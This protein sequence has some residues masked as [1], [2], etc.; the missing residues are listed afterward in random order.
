MKDIVKKL[1]QLLITLVSNN[2]CT[3]EFEINH[4]KWLLRNQNLIGFSSNISINELNYSLQEIQ[5]LL[6]SLLASALR[7][8]LIPKLYFEKLSLKQ[9]EEYGIKEISITIFEQNLYS[10]LSAVEN[11]E[12]LRGLKELAIS[13][14]N[15]KFICFNSLYE[16]LFC[17]VSRKSKGQFY[18]EL[19]IARLILDLSKIPD[20]KDII[21]IDPSCGAGAFIIA[22]LDYKQQKQIHKN[23]QILGVDIS[24]LA[25]LMSRIS[26][27]KWFN[28]NLGIKKIDFIPIF[29]M[30]YLLDFNHDLIKNDKSKKTDIIN[31]NSE[32]D[33]DARKYVKKIFSNGFDLIVGNPPYLRI[34]KIPISMREKHKELFLSATGSYDIYTL[35]IEHS[36]NLVKSNGKVSFIC[37]NKFLTA[38]YGQKIRHIIRDNTAINGFYNFTDTNLFSAQALP[39]I[40]TITKDKKQTPFNFIHLTKTSNIPARTRMKRNEFWTYLKNLVNKEVDEIIEVSNFN[41]NGKN[42]EFELNN[43]KRISVISFKANLPDDDDNWFFLSKKLEDICNKIEM[44]SNHKLVDFFNINVG[45]KTTCD[46]A[47]IF[48]KIPFK[49]KESMKYIKPIITGKDVKKWLTPQKTN[50][51]ILYPYNYEN[52]VLSPIDIDSFDEIKDYFLKHKSILESR[53]YIAESQKKW[54]EIW[55]TLNPDIFD[56]PVKIITPDISRRNRFSLDLYNKYCNGTCYIL[57]PK[58]NDFEFILYFLGFLNSELIEFYH[59]TKLDSSLFSKRWRFMYKQLK[60][61]PIYDP[62]ITDSELYQEIV[63]LAK[64]IVSESSKDNI[65]YLEE[66][67]NKKYN[68]LYNLSNEDISNIKRFLKINA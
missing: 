32:L 27:Y 47:F 21:A 55:V 31:I 42:Q 9:L 25:C 16:N 24:Y 68:E 3:D 33:S 30:D 57:G 20:D 2:V 62:R 12:I 67:L 64:Q 1:Q 52:S 4:Q 23:W 38:N 48:E 59:K 22:L 14:Q 37:S 41:G 17:N 6:E 13:I 43:D 7:L 11:E 5:F 35:F 18:T 51:Y 39:C 56:L 63:D 45:I 53:Y 50:K 29:W 58:E 44:K 66:N 49:K 40:L 19:D 34:K 60:K 65:A 10:W 26:Y 36:I 54:F 28:K 15:K 46:K 61:Y 8:S